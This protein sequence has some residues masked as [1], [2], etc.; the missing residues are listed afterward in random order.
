MRTVKAMNKKK[1]GDKM[2]IRIKDTVIKVGL[3]DRVILREKNIQVNN[4]CVASFESEEEAKK[5][6]EKVSSILEKVKWN[7]R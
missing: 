3:I 1:G 5:E 2:F 7:E 4:S 6:F